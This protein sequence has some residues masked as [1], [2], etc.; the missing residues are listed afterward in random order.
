MVPP[1]SPPLLLREPTIDGNTEQEASPPYAV[2]HVK[3][4]HASLHIPHDDDSDDA[5]V[6]W[7]HNAGWAEDVKVVRY[8]RR[9]GSGG[10]V[11][12]FAQVHKTQGLR[13]WFGHQVKG[14]GRDIVEERDFR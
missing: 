1:S 14:Q 5:R 2:L 9:L 11:D 6:V 8:Y 4:V 13:R 12:H 7:R 10:C 3:A